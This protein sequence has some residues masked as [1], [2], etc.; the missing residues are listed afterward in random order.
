[1]QLHHVNVRRETVWRADNKERLGE[2]WGEG[3]GS[4]R[5]AVSSVFFVLL[6]AHAF[7]LYPC[8]VSLVRIPAKSDVAKC[9]VIF[10]LFSAHWRYAPFCS[11]FLHSVDVTH[12][13][14]F[15]VLM[16]P[17]FPWSLYNVDVTQFPCSE[18]W[19][20]PFCSWSLHSVDVAHFSVFR[21]V[22]GPI[23]LPCTVS[24]C[25]ISFSF[26]NSQCLSVFL[27]AVHKLGFIKQ[28]SWLN[29]GRIS[30]LIQLFCLCIF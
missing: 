21:V 8:W 2:D 1:M 20:A 15:R 18:W 5:D 29:V 26:Q 9:F 17:I 6:S 27:S 23:L 28:N 10:L 11:W 24:M 3:G 19:V 30:C 25:P 4:T 7:L 14:L 13:F 22:M 16:S 12:F